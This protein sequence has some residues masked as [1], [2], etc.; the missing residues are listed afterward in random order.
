MNE[1]E[2]VK[3][4]L[5]SALDSK[6]TDL[7]TRTEECTKLRRTSED[8]QRKCE[9]Y[10][11][12]LVSL[13]DEQRND[14]FRVRNYSRVKAER[15]QLQ[16]EKIL[17]TKTN[18]E[19][20][21]MNATLKKEHSILQGN[22]CELKRKHRKQEFDLSH[23]QEQTS[24]L[25]TKLDRISEEL[26]SVSK[27]LTQERE[28]CGDLHE[29]YLSARVDVTQLTENT[30][31]QQHE[32]KLLR[33]RFEASK[34]QCSGLQDK[35]TFLSNQNEDLSADLEKSRLRFTV[36]TQSLSA[37]VQDLR[38]SLSAVTKNRD[39]LLEENS[40]LHQRIQELDIL[41]QEEKTQRR[42]ETTTLSKE[43]QRV[44]NA[45][46]TFEGL[47]EEYEKA[48]KAI[49]ALPEEETSKILERILPGSRLQGDWAVEQ[50]IQLTR[51]VLQLEGE[52][53]EAYNTIQQLTEALE[54][55]KKTVSSYKAALGLAGQP[56]SN[57]LERIASQEDQITSIHGALDHHTALKARLVE[58][59]KVLSQQVVQLK[60]GLEH[61][62][63][64]AAELNAIKKRLE[65]LLRVSP[66][67]GQT[68]GALPR[69]E[70][71]IGT[72]E[73]RP[74][75]TLPSAIIT[76]KKSKYQSR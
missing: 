30:R 52:S 62:G 59:N 44:R 28:R 72:G 38:A 7:R 39:T 34:L 24:D 25:K 58:E 69:K 63:I 21:L 37:Q 27:Q 36:D 10:A 16:E 35:V 4:S 46:S 8:L 33:E 15:D 14:D 65:S 66:E 45:L 41:Y 19:L 60:Q 9:Q 54:H 67:P 48:V 50:C 5:E 42:E 56:S 18:N 75:R 31:D 71:E 51:R 20:E 32:I 17:S 40:R 53:L 43:L 57:L 2:A 61:A 68:R 70:E 47:P 12:Q 64:E 13:K 6:D 11:S 22:F 49:A 26:G 74:S 1:L 3:S 23:Y 73:R 29:K 76:T 55:L